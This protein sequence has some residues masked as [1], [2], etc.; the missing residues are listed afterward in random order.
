MRLTE[1]QFRGLLHSP[2]INRLKEMIH[3][4]RVEARGLRKEIRALEALYHDAMKDRRRE[5][6]RE[7]RA[8]KKAMAS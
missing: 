1:E 3:Q 2:D 5:R 4:R 7:N 8:K 6:A